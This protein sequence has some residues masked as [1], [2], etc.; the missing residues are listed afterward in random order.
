MREWIV[1]GG[2][3]CVGGGHGLGDWGGLV[4]SSPV[5]FIESANQQSPDS[6]I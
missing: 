4:M 1:V 5:V 3:W 6:F 2:E